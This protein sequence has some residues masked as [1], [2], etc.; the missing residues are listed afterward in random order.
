MR[1]YVHGNEK[2][3]ILRAIGLLSPVLSSP[4]G[5]P[6]TKHTKSDEE[7]LGMSPCL[8]YLHA[9]DIISTTERMSKKWTGIYYSFFKD[10]IKV[11]YM[12]DNEKQKYHEFTCLHPSC[13]AIVWHYLN[14]KEASS[15][16]SLKYHVEDVCKA[17][18]LTSQMLNFTGKK[19]FI[20]CFNHTVNLVGKTPLEAVQRTEAIRGLQ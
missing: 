9:I 14:M 1:L 3:E 8:N 19:H 20:R 11:K 7:E 17:W 2:P 12:N 6:F 16:G 13:G 4:I 18:A 15:T 5:M 10:N